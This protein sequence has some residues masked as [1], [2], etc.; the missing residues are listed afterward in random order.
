MGRV[1][2]SLHCCLQVLHDLVCL[3]LDVLRVDVSGFRV[4]GDLARDEKQVSNCSDWAVGANNLEASWE[5]SFN[6]LHDINFIK[7]LSM[8]SELVVK[9]H[10][11]FGKSKF[12]KYL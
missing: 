1:V 6:S 10:F 8:L 4:E 3:P 12:Y 7:Y 5:N 9:Y 11:I 2:C